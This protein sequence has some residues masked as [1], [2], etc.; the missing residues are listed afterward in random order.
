LH[1]APPLCGLLGRGAATVLG[2]ERVRVAI[3]P[4]IT[5]YLAVGP[6][7]LSS[8][9]DQVNARSWLDADTATSTKAVVTMHGDFRIILLV[10]SLNQVA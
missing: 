8:R 5:G 4:H 6:G 2:E 1:P 9:C 7:S 10:W 3:D